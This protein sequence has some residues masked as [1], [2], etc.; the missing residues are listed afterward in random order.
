MEIPCRAFGQ[1]AWQQIHLEQKVTR[2]GTDH[3]RLLCAGHSLLPTFVFFAS[4][5]GQESASPGVHWSE[6]ITYIT[7]QESSVDAVIGIPWEVKKDQ[8]GDDGG[9]W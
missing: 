2:L 9:Q 1:S 8:K 7:C 6:L 4:V 5:A 3:A